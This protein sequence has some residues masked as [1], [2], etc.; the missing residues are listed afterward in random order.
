MRVVPHSPAAD[1]LGCLNPKLLLYA[2]GFAVPHQRTEGLFGE[3][4]TTR[5]GEEL[6]RVGARGCGAGG[7][8]NS[9]VSH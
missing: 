5:P 9:L 7:F 3:L 4:R 6:C 2:G 8:P 1:P